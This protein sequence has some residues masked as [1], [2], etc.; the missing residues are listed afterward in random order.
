MLQPGELWSQFAR[1]HS[2]RAWH[3]RVGVVKKVER[4]EPLPNRRCQG[5]RRGPPDPSQ[6]RHSPGS[7]LHGAHRFR[8]VHATFLFASWKRWTFDLS[9]EWMTSSLLHWSLVRLR[10]VSMILLSRVRHSH[11]IFTLPLSKRG[12]IER[13][14]SPTSL[15]SGPVRSFR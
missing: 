7:R 9:P 15:G 4:R 12:A 11:K 5:T 2:A 10:G 8:H 13:L 1:S 6:S 3:Y 14:K